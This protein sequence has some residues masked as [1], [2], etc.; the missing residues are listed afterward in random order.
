MSRAYDE[1]DDSRRSFLKLAGFTLVAGCTRGVEHK[2]IPLLN[3]VEEITPGRPTWYATSCDGCAAGCGVLAK[4]RVGRPIKLEGNP[5]HALSRGGLCATGQASVLGLYDSQRLAKPVLSG[6]QAEWGE[7]DAAIRQRLAGVKGG[8]RVLT[9]TL[10]GPTARGAIERFC[11]KFADARHVMYDAL[12]VSALLDVHEASLGRRALPRFRFDKAQVIVGFDADFLGTWI[13]PAEFTRD[14]RA[15]RSLTKGAVHSHHT[16]FESHFTVTGSN[17]DQRIVVD[18]EGLGRSIAGL[19]AAVARR[20]DKTPPT[21]AKPDANVDAVAKRLVDAPRGKTLVVCG[22][23]DDESQMLVAAI[24]ALLGNYGSTLETARPSFQRLGS[25]GGLLKLRDE[26]E[27]GEVG[28]LLIAGCNP[29]YDLP[30]ELALDRVGLIVSFAERLDETASR[31][32]FVCPDHHPLEG[33]TDVQPIDGFFTLGQPLVKPLRDTRALVE[34]LAAF[35]GD[36]KASALEIMRAT[37]REQVYPRRA[38]RAESFDLFWSRALHDGFVDV[39]PAT[40]EAPKPIRTTD[41]KPP[42]AK[43]REAGQFALVAHASVAMLDGS[44]GH[45]AWLHELPDPVTKLTWDNCASLS[46]AAAERLGI[47]AGDL[48]DVGGLELPA[49]IQRGQHNE[50]VAIA[51]GYGRQGTERFAGIGPQWLEGSPT[52]DEGQLVGVN[53]F[54]LLGMGAVEVKPTG[55]RRELART[56]DHHALTPPDGLGEKRSGI[57]RSTT[58]AEYRKDPASGNPHG[59]EVHSLWPDDHGDRERHWGMAIDLSACTGCSACL[60]ACQAENNVPVVGRDEVARHREMHWIRIDRYQDGDEVVHQPML[61]QHCDNAPCETVCPVLATV[62]S[63]DGLNQQ[64]Y[65]R[66]VGTRYCANNCP[67]KARRFNWFEY[68]HDDS[69][70]N[71]GLNPDVAVR[72]RGVMEKCSLCIQRIAEARAE[73]RRAGR[74]IRDGEIQPACM[75][76]CPARAITFG[77]SLD[78]KSALSRARHDPRHYHVLADLDT[79]PTVGYLTQVRNRDA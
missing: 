40:I 45:N 70:Q 37:Y 16:Q 48:V 24:N 66:C 51:V 52:V 34:S 60:I 46:P 17:A 29:V 27:K 35:G 76:S 13:S 59:H 44:H 4:S 67:Y 69:L 7:V 41:L 64:V 9:G 21:G 65:N 53:A 31:A 47:E 38:N 79:R 55:G 5:Q 72:S 71:L 56:Q 61:C 57:A 10:S 14:Y 62:Q 22:S 25:D 33:W 75:Q 12:S 58:L 8:V 19:A 18:P 74:D 36:E 78:E 42:Q 50:V 30:F 2:A 39:G 68:R 23:L 26:I 54:K 63:S 28:T 49:L 73:A 15:G 3:P 43:P 1:A 77:D 6:D 20:L 32:H 11:R